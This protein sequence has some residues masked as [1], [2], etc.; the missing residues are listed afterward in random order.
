MVLGLGCDT[1]ATMT[2]RI[3]SSRK[4]R[5]IVMFL[6]S[7]AVPCSA[8]IGVIGGMLANL[9]AWAMALWVGVVVGV[10]LGIGKLAAMVIPG[11]GSDFIMELPPFRKPRLSNI[12]IKTVARV[13][14]YIK[15][16]AP[17]FI[18]ATA[19]LFVLHETG[20][21]ILLRDFSAP[22]V[23]HFLGLPAAA[24]DAFLI[25]FFR[26]DYGAAGLYA[27]ALDGRMDSVQMVVSIITITLFVPCV[28]HVLMMFKE[29]GKK[30]TLLTL[31]FVF[32]FAFLVGGVVNQVLR[33]FQ[34]TF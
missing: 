19:A 31:A 29:A 21:L 5:M 2:T 34:I 33:Y 32:P 15:E 24:A 1:M 4:E 17:L 14:W 26:R 27:L 6:L 22:V 13:E 8:Q 25:G 18:M 23:Q 3:L 9:N 30:A 28:A 11:D 12:V 10:L 16:V 7:L 20:M